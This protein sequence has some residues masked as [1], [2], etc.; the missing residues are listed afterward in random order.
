[1]DKGRKEMK[2][3]ME[4]ERMGTESKEGVRGCH[5]RGNGGGEST[6]RSMCSDVVV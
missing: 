5:G 6:T 1:M 2:D 4:R 3:E